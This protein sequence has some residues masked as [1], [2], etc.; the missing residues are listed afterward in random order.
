MSTA[1]KLI[2]VATILVL[3]PAQ[4]MVR[5][6]EKLP[7]KY[8]G[9]LEGDVAY[10][11]SKEEKE[12]FLKL[13]RDDDREKFIE[14]FW[15]LRNPTPGAPTNPYKDEH[16][17]RLAYANQHF[18][19]ESGT[20]GWRADQGRVYITLGPPQQRAFYTNYANLRPFEIWFYSSSHPALAPFFYVVFYRR[21]TTSD[22]RLYSPY[23][24]GPEKLVTT[25]R[26][27]NNRVA[28]LRV[29][30]QSAGREV[31]RTTLSLLPDEPV[32]L[33]TATASLQSDVLLSHIR[34]LA[35]DPLTK[36]D[37]DRRRQILES[38]T[39]RLILGGEFLDVLALPLRDS[40]GHTNLHYA[41]R[42]KRPEEF[43]VGRT[44]D[45]R[46]YYSVSIAA[47]VFGA[48]S[49]Q[50][51]AQEKKLSAYFDENQL[52]QIKNK[53]FGYEGLLPLPPGKYKIEFALTNLLKQTAYRAEKEVVVPEIP[54]NGI[55][56]TPLV[57]FSTMVGVDPAERGLVP[58]SAAGVRFD[59]L[60]GQELNLQP[61][62][63]L[64]IFY[65]IWTTPKDP[66]AYR[67]HKLTL[68]YVYGRLGMRGDSKVIRD[69]ALKEQFD[70]S[71]SLVNGK[72][73]PLTDL[74]E[75]N[76]LLSV[77]VTDPQTQQKAYSTLGFRVSS[78][79]NPAATWDI[80]DKDASEDASKGLAD[81]QR[82]L[83]YLAFGDKERATEWFRKGLGKDPA[84]EEARA[85]LVD[86][87]FSRQAFAEVAELYAAAQI[88]NR[89]EERTILR[90]ADSLDRLGNT[91]KAI[92]LLQSALNLKSQ[93][94]PLYLALASYYRRAGDLQTAA[95]L[96]RKG[97]ALLD[98]AQPSS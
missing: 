2:L 49:K 96:E 52:G 42:M 23:A 77:N 97:K 62:Q 12:V 66:A 35:N 59:P 87:L 7:P 16:Y 47:R 83:C 79:S 53:I 14:R 30:D 50:I 86:L 28:A 93:S 6:A 65:Q 10:I 9:W 21:E 92:S 51:F 24:D 5:A 43:T 25:G 88:N 48:D 95:E 46:Y 70:R 72:K 26:A 45:G 73:I 32:D 56:L 13:T 54:S 34:N 29:I 11:I 71:G 60:L 58:F 36:R 69:E 67:G 4:S 64:K 57:P 78:A 63:D 18:G 22:Y 44:S 74:P 17:R 84:N 82:G 76:Y 94:G 55:R 90:V 15:E 20:E 80:Y 19:R 81:Y 68:E 37:I 33:E 3:A 85:K 31:A 38:V 91:K 40:E 27:T 41:L 61:G 8:R 89:T 75:G 98:Q 39:S 1:T